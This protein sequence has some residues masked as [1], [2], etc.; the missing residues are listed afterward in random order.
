M[1]GFTQASSE[2]MDEML[3][4]HPQ[5]GPPSI[6]ADPVPPPVQVVCVD[7]VRALRSFPSGTAPGPSCLRANHVKEAV[8]CP[9]PDRANFAL[10]GL[11]GV[12][13]L[14]CAGRAPPSILPYLCGATLLACRKK[15]GGFRPIAMGEVLYVYLGQYKLMPLRYSH[16][17]RLGL[18]YR[19][20]VRVLFIQL[21]A[22]REIQT[23]H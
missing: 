14:L 7:I 10:Q 2:V 19:L 13:N 17:F 21:Q 5:S 1:E 15:G 3:S 18:G 22:F 16:L 23:S 4:K 9:S 6:P 20:A 11:V 12:V 8:F